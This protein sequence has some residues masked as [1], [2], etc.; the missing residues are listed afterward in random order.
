MGERGAELDLAD[1]QGNILR[2]YGFRYGGYLFVAV[3]HPV[4]GR[5]W[6]DQVRARVTSA[7]PWAGGA[8]PE[9]TLNLA[10]SAAG[11]RCLGVPAALVATFG[12]AFREGMSA[13]A[14]ALGDIGCSA[15]EEWDEGLKGDLHVVVMVHGATRDVALVRL[16]SLRKQVDAA[17]GVDLVDTLDCAGLDYDREHFGFGDGFGQPAVEGSGHDHMP[18]QG[19]PRWYGGW[20][21]LKAGEFVLGYPDEDLEAPPQPA[22]ALGVNGSYMV[23][24]KLAQDVRAFRRFVREAAGEHGITE[25]RVAASIVGRWKDGTPLALSPDAPDG[26]IAN[27]RRR[28]NDFGYRHDPDGARCPVGSHIRRVHP[29]DGLDAQGRL[30]LRHRMIR[31]GMPYGDP[32]RKGENEDDP[33]GL[34]FVCY[35]ADIE[36]QFEDVQRQWCNDG[37]I[38]HMRTDRDFLSPRPRQHGDPPNV[39]TIA[40]R[41][42]VFLQQPHEPFVTL[43]G[44]GY[45][46]APGLR[47]LR[48]IAAGAW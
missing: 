11:L 5:A 29:R 22:A 25:D 19:V 10:V 6:L 28:I 16:K 37:D 23:L 18:G 2:P 15:P 20:R 1:I 47:A 14:P 26:T 35:V 41:K 40:G 4:A 38:G 46:F 17:P 27:D 32:Y 43:N 30:T 39:L 7:A 33:R 8:K 44:G 13:R 48:A 42:P 21:S 36:R 12:D 34:A 3:R 24:R 9:A 45:F 31:R